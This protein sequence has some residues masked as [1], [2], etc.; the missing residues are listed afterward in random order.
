MYI[1]Y[2]T[3]IPIAKSPSH[4]R[5]PSTPPAESDTPA[6]KETAKGKGKMH[7]ST[8][9]RESTTDRDIHTSSPIN[10]WAISFAIH[11][12]CTYS[13]ALSPP[14]HH[15]DMI[16]FPRFTLPQLGARRR[17][18]LQLKRHLLKLRQQAT[19][20]FPAQRSPCT[21][22]SATHSSITTPLRQLSKALIL[23][24]TERQ[25]THPVAPYPHYTP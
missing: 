12:T 8:R 24:T 4:H 11:C 10:S 19:A 5:F 3:T 9:N 16:P 1:F 2:E 25:Q 6:G 20:R 23:T 13:P 21:P 22:V 14:L 15:N 17:T 7:D 18:R